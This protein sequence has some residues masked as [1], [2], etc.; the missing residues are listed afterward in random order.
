MKM[1]RQYMMIAL[2]L[3]G[4]GALAYGIVSAIVS[5]MKDKEANAFLE[6]LT[7]CMLPASAGLQQNKAFD[8]N[9]WKTAQD[10]SNDRAVLLR[11]GEPKRL[12]EQIA[13]ARGG[14]FGLGN[15]NEDQ[16]FEVYSTVQDKAQASQVAAAFQG[17]PNQGRLSDALS[18][19]LSATE[20]T[21]ILAQVN[22]LPDYRT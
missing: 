14:L 22:Q 11:S 12:A 6:E 21:Q 13:D 9:Y 17:L 16:I 19:W 1:N 3:A 18:Q 8:P 10:H 7:Q 5:K 20:I 4:G 2:G 15:D